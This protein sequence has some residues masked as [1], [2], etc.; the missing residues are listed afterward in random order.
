VSGQILL[1]GAGG[2]GVA[3]A[4]VVE[5]DGRFVIA[6]FAGLASDFGRRVGGYEVIATDADLAQLRRTVQN[7]LITVGQI[8]N[9]DA[10]TR[11]WDLLHAQGWS[12]PTIV[13]PRA[14]VSPRATL[15]QGTIVLHGAVINAGASVGANCIVNSQALIEHDTTIGDHCHIS[16]GAIL[17]GG[18]H[19]GAGSFIGSGTII[20]QGVAVAERCMIG[21][22]QSIIGD[23]LAGS[24]ITRGRKLV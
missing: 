24:R 6:G 21:M 22:G 16:T 13:S 7:A 19:V 14:Y 1:I 15:G 9:A 2:H 11:L 4:D 3:C 17:N 8:E 5:Q 20:R 12:L 18:V 10:R 23:C